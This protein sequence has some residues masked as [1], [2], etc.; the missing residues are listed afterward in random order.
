MGQ[1]QATTKNLNYASWQYNCIV[2]RKG[3]LRGCIIP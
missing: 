1:A 2:S 3:L